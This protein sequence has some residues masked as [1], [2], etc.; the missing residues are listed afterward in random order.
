M[1]PKGDGARRS[2]RFS[3]SRFNTETE[4]DRAIEIVPKVIDKL[5]QTVRPTSVA[6]AEPAAP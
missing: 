1:N 4:I 6:T 5:R 2:L 3:F